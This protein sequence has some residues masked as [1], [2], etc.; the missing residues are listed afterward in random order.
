MAAS[1]PEGRVAPSTYRKLS[2][3]PSGDHC[4]LLAKPLSVA[5]RRGAVSEPGLAE[6]DSGLVVGSAVGKEGKLL[7]VGRP[8]EAALPAFLAGGAGGDRFWMGWIA[9][10][11][12]LNASGVPGDEVAVW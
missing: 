8:G 2:S 4:R 11:R 12:N 6:E 7:R 1:A 5:S 10:R 3:L 9:Q